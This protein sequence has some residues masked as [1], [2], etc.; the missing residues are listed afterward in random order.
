M[1]RKTFLQLFALALG[2]LAMPLSASNQKTKRAPAFFIGHGSPMNAL[3]DNEFTRSLKVVGK[4]IEKPKAILMV[5]AHWTPPYTG[6]T[7]HE[8]SKLMYDFFGFPKELDEIRYPA[9]NAKFLSPQIKDMFGDIKIKNRSLD[10]GAWTVLLHMFPDADIPVMQFGINSKFS[11]QEH[12]DLAKKLRVLRDQGVMIIGSGNV[13]HNLRL[14]DRSD[15]AQ[16]VDWAEDF[17]EFVKESIIERDFD[18]LVAFDKANE[19]ANLAHPTLEHYIPLLY[20]AGVA[21]E[22]DKTLFPYEGIEF[23]TLSMRNWLLS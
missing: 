12:F 21:Y 8:S 22:S 7:V 11:L 16:V 15:D 19:Y 18:A 17:D 23:G 5:S 13:T 1:T 2:G 6:V 4:M 14:T 3:M 10:H 9:P 20:V